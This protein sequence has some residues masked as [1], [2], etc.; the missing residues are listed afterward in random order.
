M[1]SLFDTWFGFIF[2]GVA[3]FQMR[4]QEQGAGW[5]KRQGIYGNIMIGLNILLIITGLVCLGPGTYSAVQSIVTNY[6]TGSVSGVFS[7]AN[8][9]FKG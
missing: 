5:W 9:G 6:Q 2:W 1:S 4:G 7:C 3:Y 8:N